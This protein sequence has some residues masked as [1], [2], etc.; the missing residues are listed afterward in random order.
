VRFRTLAADERWE[1]YRAN[2]AA[3]SAALQLQ[4]SDTA[5]RALEAAPA[6]HRNWEWRHLHSQLD[7]ARRVVRLPGR[8]LGPLA[9]SAAAGQ[10][11]VFSW[12]DDRLPLYDAATGQAGPVLRGHTGNLTGVDYR[13]D[14]RQVATSATDNTVRLWDPKTGRE[15]AELPAPAPALKLLYSPDSRRLVALYSPDNRR[16]AAPAALPGGGWL[17][18]THST[19]RP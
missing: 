1:N 7:G 9:Y 12:F 17:R 4:N 3:A 8:G 10:F 19:Q 6:E 15:V 11:A 2:I 5:R 18:G 13:P 16:L 14:G